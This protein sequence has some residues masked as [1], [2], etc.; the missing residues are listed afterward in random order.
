MQLNT[1][2]NRELERP[3]SLHESQTDPLET[4]VEA[5]DLGHGT[6]EYRP[7]RP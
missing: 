7:P 5:V 4:S 3:L 1:Y 6:F 2:L